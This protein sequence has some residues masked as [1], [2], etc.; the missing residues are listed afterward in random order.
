MNLYDVRSE[1]TGASKLTQN[2]YALGTS[3][4]VMWSIIDLVE[5]AESETDKIKA[6]SDFRLSLIPFDPP[7]QITSQLEWTEL[8]YTPSSI[9]PKIPFQIQ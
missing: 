8:C 1:V 2:R 3:A 7:L 4:C 5:R 6:T 9:P